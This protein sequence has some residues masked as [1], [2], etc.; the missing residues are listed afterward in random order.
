MSEKLRFLEVGFGN[1]P[2][3]TQGGTLFEDNSIDYY[4]V[5]P[6]KSIGV[7]GKPLLFDDSQSIRRT[8]Q[9]TTNEFPN[10]HFVQALVGNLPFKSNHFDRVFMRSVFGQFKSGADAWITSIETVMGDG[11][12][13]SF[14][15]LKPGGKIVVLEENTP[16]REELSRTYLE[17][18]GFTITDSATMDGQFS[19]ERKNQKWKEL[20]KPYFKGRPTQ[21]GP[22][23]YFDTPYILIGQ[24]P[25]E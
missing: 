10:A 23:Y 17:N 7:M 5:E 15:V 24:K 18:V 16:W 1:L 21:D 13:E 9:V 19:E 14:R 8:A 25:E 22:G 6:M 12:R 3:V 20:R 4:G 2:A 11:V